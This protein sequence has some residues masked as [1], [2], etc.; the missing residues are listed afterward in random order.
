MKKLLLIFFVALLG[1]CNFSSREIIT[2]EKPQID[3]IQIATNSVSANLKIDVQAKRKLQ[4]SA[5]DLSIFDKKGTKIG[6]LRTDDIQI[7]KG[8]NQLEIPLKFYISTS[9]LKIMSIIKSGDLD[10]LQIKGS[11]KVKSG[12]FGKRIEFDNISIR[13]FINGYLPQVAD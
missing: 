10:N 13:D 9:P 7:S 3:N 1:S 5:T 12:L 8:A 11:V 4:F 2:A 6:I